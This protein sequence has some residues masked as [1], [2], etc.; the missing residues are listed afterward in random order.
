MKRLAIFVALAICA[1]PSS[2]IAASQASGKAKLHPHSRSGISA[3]IVFVDDGTTLWTLGAARGLDPG[4]EYISLIYDN[5][6]VPGG[7]L[8]CEPG[9]FDPTDPDF[10]LPTMFLGVWT[11][12]PDGTGTV[13]AEDVEVGTAYVSL[14]K[15]KTVSIRSA[16]S[17]FDVVACGEVGAWRP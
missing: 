6:S 5:K 16:S 1:F 9:I 11:V 17:G 14:D 8:A 7:P 10:I 15:I 2:S 3:T 4:D 13:V 12:N